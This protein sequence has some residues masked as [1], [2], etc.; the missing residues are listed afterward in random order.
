[1]ASTARWKS[2][3]N[4]W[5]RSGSII[6]NSFMK[7]AQEIKSSC[8]NCIKVQKQVKSPT[9]TFVS[10]FKKYINVTLWRQRVLVATESPSRDWKDTGLIPPPLLHRDSPVSLRETPNP[11]CHRRGWARQLDD[12]RTTRR[13]INKWCMRNY[14]FI[15]D[16]QSG[17]WESAGSSPS[18]LIPCFVGHNFMLLQSLM[19]VDVWFD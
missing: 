13:M 3:K 16:S 9:G 10:S 6:P 18:D 14:I 17:V 1:M 5:K 8:Q 7:D 11:F 19:C 12:C 4:E 2:R 15:P